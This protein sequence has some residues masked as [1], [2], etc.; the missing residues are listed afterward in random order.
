MWLS[1]IL[2]LRL[3]YM[4]GAQVLICFIGYEMEGIFA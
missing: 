3:E 1:P 4:L 2:T